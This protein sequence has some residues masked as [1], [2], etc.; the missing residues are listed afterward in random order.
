MIFP[1]PSRK[2]LFGRDYRKLGRLLPG[3][4]SVYA[5]I[6]GSIPAEESDEEFSVAVEE[7]S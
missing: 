6:L 7:L 5:R 3:E 2:R 1:G 4:P